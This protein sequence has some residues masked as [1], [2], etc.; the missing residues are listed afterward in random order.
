LDYIINLKEGRIMYREIAEDLQDVFLNGSYS[1]AWPIGSALASDLITSKFVDD[2]IDYLETKP[3]IY[4]FEA[5]DYFIILNPKRVPLE[6]KKK[7]MVYLFDYLKKSRKDVYLRTSIELN[8]PPKVISNPNLIFKEGYSKIIFLLS[9]L[10]EIYN[11]IYRRLN[12]DIYTKDGFLYRYYRL[13]NEYLL[14]SK[15]NAPPK[16]SFFG[17]LQEVEKIT[18]YN[19]YVNGKEVDYNELESKLIYNLNLFKSKINFNSESDKLLYVLNACRKHIN[20]NPLT[21]IDFTY[22]PADYDISFEKKQYVMK[23]STQQLDFSEKYYENL[24]E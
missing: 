1:Q 11:P 5:S 7:A 23:N 22:N 9:N 19:C 10:S 8:N 18:E 16:L 15:Y 20:L 14:V 24:L 17:H 6:H 21:S 4:P 12:H 3:Y 13:D 2:L